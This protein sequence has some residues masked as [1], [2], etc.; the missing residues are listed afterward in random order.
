MLFQNT[1]QSRHLDPLK[2]AQLEAVRPA[3]ALTVH[4]VAKGEYDLEHVKKETSN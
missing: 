1:L 4:V 2:Y 3:A